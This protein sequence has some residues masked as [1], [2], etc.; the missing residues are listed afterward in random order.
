MTGPGRAGRVLVVDDEPLNRELLEDLLAPLGYEVETA[1]DGEEALRAVRDS[2]PDVVLLDVMMPGMDG[3]QVARRLKSGEE[4]RPIPIVMVT[5]LT[6]VADRVR[7]L[8]AGAGDFLTKPVDKAELRATVAA[9]VQVKAYHD[10]MAR[11]QQELQAEVDRRT[12]ELRRALERVAAA[13]LETIIRLSRAAEYKDEDTGRHVMRMSLSAACIARRLGLP[14]ADVDALRS[15]A[16]LHDIGK[17]GVPDHILLKPG[18]LTIQE[19]E[20]MKQHTRIG[21]K[22]LQGS[23]SEVIRLGETIALTHHE[24]WDGTGYPEGLREAGIPLPGRVTAIA[25]VFDALMSKRPY[26]PAYPAAQALRIIRRERGRHFDPDVVDAFFEVRE[27]IL[28]IG[29]RHRDDVEAVDPLRV[30][31]R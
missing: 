4:T 22:I 18:S 26:K 14:E 25:D 21:G 31:P 28:A 9:Q 8:E 24:R 10:H 2:P 29:E 7:A 16:P 1:Q 20:I 6:E 3:F 12:A 5:S 17:I 23:D 27:E 19:W 15:A 30:P 13:S 11:Y